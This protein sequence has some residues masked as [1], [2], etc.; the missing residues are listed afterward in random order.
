MIIIMMYIKIHNII[1]MSL[2]NTKVA[3]IQNKKKNKLFSLETT[4]EQFLFVI[5]STLH[6]LNS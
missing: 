6:R 4:F 2:L 1:F 3:V 5:R